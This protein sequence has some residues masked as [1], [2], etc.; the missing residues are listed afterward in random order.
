MSESKSWGHRKKKKKKVTKGSIPETGVHK[1][2]RS[3]LV[4]VPALRKLHLELNTT[5][6]AA[7]D[8]LEAC[9]RYK[10]F[11]GEK[12]QR[13]LWEYGN[14]TC[15]KAHGEEKL[16]ADDDFALDL[17]P[18]WW[19]NIISRESRYGRCWVLE[20][21]CRITHQSCQN[22]LNNLYERSQE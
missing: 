16:V 3:F 17:R 7:T 2:F 14:I 6:R 13:S 15:S 21:Q 22:Y 19:R 11:E 1:E 18:P 9:T 12:A 8:T 10:S 4:V 5:M 20:I